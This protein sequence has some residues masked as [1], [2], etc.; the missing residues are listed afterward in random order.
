MAQH[1]KNLETLRHPSDMAYIPNGVGKEI[2]IN[3]AKLDISVSQ[4]F[5]CV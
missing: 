3:W 5:N 2:Q 4:I 1:H